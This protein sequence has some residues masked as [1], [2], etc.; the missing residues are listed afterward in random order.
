VT[1]HYKRPNVAGNSCEMTYEV[2]H[3]SDKPCFQKSI[4]Y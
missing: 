2:T 1:G 3:F 4:R